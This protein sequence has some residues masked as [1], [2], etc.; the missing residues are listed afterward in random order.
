MNSKDLMSQKI[1]IISL[2]GGAVF[3]IAFVL[4]EYAGVNY[5]DIIPSCLFRSITGLYCPGC[6]LR[7]AI[8]ELANFNL[9]ESFTH[10]PA[11]IYSIAIYIP[12]VI[13]HAVYEIS[14][15]KTRVFPLK[16]VYI[17]ICM[18]IIIFNCIVKNAV[19][20]LSL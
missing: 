11:L 12:C 19:I 10:Y 3:I 4:S 6:G 17:Y 9:A 15:K 18:G 16:A 20:I 8:K 7:S 1:L 2:I 5:L 14:G 13:S